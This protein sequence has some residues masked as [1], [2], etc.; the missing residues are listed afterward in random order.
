VA[1]PSGTTLTSLTPTIITA[2]GDATVSP[3]S[4]TS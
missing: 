2:S 3:D 1:V 4:G